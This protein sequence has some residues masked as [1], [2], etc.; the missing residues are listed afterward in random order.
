MFLVELF[1]WTLPGVGV[2]NVDASFASESPHSPQPSPS[3][4]LAHV[5]RTIAIELASEIIG[6]ELTGGFGCEGERRE[7]YKQEATAANM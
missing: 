3:H 5:S 2:N 6:S 1:G 4:A 7:T